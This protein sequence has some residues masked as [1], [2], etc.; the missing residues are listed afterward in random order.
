MAELEIINLSKSFGES[1][2]I[3]NISFEVCDCEFCI[4]LGPSGSGKSTML[5]LISG[6]ERQDSGEI[7]IGGTEVSGLT[8]K[9]RDIAMV[10]QS[11]ALYP[12]MSARENIAFPMK[13]KGVAKEE[14]K[15]KTWEVAGLLNI[16]DVLDRKPGE[17]SG[18]QRQ[19]VALGRAIVRNPKL[20][21][22]DE[23]LSNL[24]AKLRFAMRAELARLHQRLKT[25]IVYVTHDQTEAMTLGDKIIL[26]DKGRVQ[27]IGSPKE[28]YKRP[29]NLFVAA[30]IGSPQ[31][32]FIRG[33]VQVGSEG[34]SFVTEGFSLRLAV[35]EELEKYDGLEVTLGVRPESLS[36][37]KG[38][39]SGEIELVEH[40][41]PETLVFLKTHSVEGKI[42]MK[43][44]SDFEGKA[45]DRLS[46]KP[47]LEGL[48]FFY[49]GNRIN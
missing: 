47:D 14:I 35:E 12:H 3:D 11:Y 17:I 16:K 6:L 8:P 28:I 45:G 30:F 27:Q 20:F 23:P 41:G 38:P 18:G 19:R 4:L 21:L 43:A 1:R 2:V 33:R 15:K 32:N 13:M 40:L 31:M 25:T 37:G 29:V 42:V 39:I 7:R 9:E 48:H 10:F 26:L 36:I 5:R 44:S 46:L 34:I 24:D 22:F 49:E